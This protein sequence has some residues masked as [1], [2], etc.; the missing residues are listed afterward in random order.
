MRKLA[1]IQRVAEIKPIP[2]ADLI[3]AYRINGW[4]IVD[5]KDQYKVGDFV[6]YFEVDSW[7]PT[8]LASFLSKGKEPR[9][10]NGVKGEKLR[11]IKLKKQLSQGLIL[12]IQI[13][14]ERFEGSKFDEGQELAEFFVEGADVSELLG[15]QKWEPPE[16]PGM[17]GQPRGNF[18]SFIP[19]TDQERIQNLSKVLSELWSTNDWQWE[20]TEK[21]EGSSLTAYCYEGEVGVCSRNIDL[22]EDDD[23]AFWRVAKK[24]DIPTKLKEL[25]RNIAIQGEMVGPSIQCNIYKLNETDFYV[26][27]VYDITTGSYLN[28]AERVALVQQLGL[29]H[30]PIVDIISLRDATMQS[31]LDMAD[32][33]SKLRAETNRE[34]LVFKACE[35]SEST[36]KAISNIYLLKQE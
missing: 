22:K 17:G 29:K 10:F 18:P 36:F 28:P 3:V 20:V 2:E 12:P 27:D 30:V 25:G 21:L 33:K 32:G 6:V 7:I 15:V 5:K 16:H 11:T 9:E 8:E 13:A 14:F 19:K 1:S 4:W 31:L 23:N 26:F 34:G 24:Y 35:V